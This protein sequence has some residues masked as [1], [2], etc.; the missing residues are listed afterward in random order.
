MDSGK[1]KKLR[2][3]LDA[4][5]SFIDRAWETHF[6][7]LSTPQLLKKIRLVNAMCTKI[8]TELKD[9]EGQQKEELAALAEHHKEELETLGM[10]M[11]SSLQKEGQ[12]PC[13]EDTELMEHLNF[14]LEQHE[15]LLN[16]QEKLIVE[17]IGVFTGK[18]TDVEVLTKMR[19][20]E[21]EC[22]RMLDHLRDENFSPEDQERLVK[23]FEARLEDIQKDIQEFEE[24]LRG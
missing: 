20:L 16:A 2:G 14:Y 19:H 11:E 3:K 4:I 10:L 13:E 15:V 5:N 9:E 6:K 21:S 23:A 8:L 18:T 1:Y 7:N 24:A 12:L 17:Q 22:Q